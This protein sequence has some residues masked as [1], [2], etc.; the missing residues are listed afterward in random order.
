MIQKIL[1]LKS[2][3]VTKKCFFFFLQNLKKKKDVEIVKY[4]FFNKKIAIF[5][6]KNYN[7]NFF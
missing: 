5:I 7:Y 2:A 6:T 4:F 3:D 1:I